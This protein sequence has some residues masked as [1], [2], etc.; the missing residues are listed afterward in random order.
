M[1][2]SVDLTVQDSDIY[3]VELGEAQGE[4]Q[5]NYDVT[6]AGD[7]QIIV[8]WNGG[9]V[10]SSGVVNT[11][12]TLTFT[13]TSIFPTTAQINIIMANATNPIVDITTQCPVYPTLNVVMITV[14]NNY[15]AGET[16][17]NG[18]GYTQG[19]VQSVVTPNF[20]APPIT[21]VSGTASPLVSD[22]QTY[23]AQPGIVTGKQIEPH[24]E[25]IQNHYE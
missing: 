23:T 21:F 15:E 24:L 20:S 22:F 19:G 17:H 12:G 11:G 2:V 13:K 25:Y 3:E 8:S 5:I 6:Q 10:A 7:F 16:I 9:V 1:Q 14:T 4:V 18:F